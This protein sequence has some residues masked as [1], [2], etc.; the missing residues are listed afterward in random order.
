YDMNAVEALGLIK[1]DLL[2]QR[3]LTTMSLALEEI[4]RA[5][6]KPLGEARG[7]RVDFDTIPEADPAT[8]AMISE[9]RTMGVFQIESPGMRRQSAACRS[10]RPTWC[11]APQ[12]NLP[13][14]ASV[15]AC[16]R[17]S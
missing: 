4:E 14:S 7:K 8:C 5:S 1:M 12:Q 6:G 2:G 13:T 15:S 17:S 16:A 11:A 10:L 9:G 3:G